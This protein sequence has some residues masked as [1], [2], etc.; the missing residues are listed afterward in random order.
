MADLQQTQKDQILK[1]F[2]HQLQNGSKKFIIKFGY[3]SQVDERDEDSEDDFYDNVYYDECEYYG[4]H[5]YRPVNSPAMNDDEYELADRINKEFEGDDCST[6]QRF[7]YE[8]QTK[9]RESSK[10]FCWSLCFEFLPQ[11][12]KVGNDYKKNEKQPKKQRKSSLYHSNTRFSEKAWI[13]VSFENT[14]FA[15]NFLLTELCDAISKKNL[16]DK[17]GFPI[18]VYSDLDPKKINEDILQFFCTI[19]N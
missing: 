17:I 18:L 14:A 3:D 8:D 1:R 13:K 4:Y 2:K 5:D 19:Q 9:I 12:K 7:N 16:L 6:T 10:E 15:R 11:K